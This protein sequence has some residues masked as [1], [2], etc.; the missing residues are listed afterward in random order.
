M[1][2]Y[3]KTPFAPNVPLSVAGFPVYLFGGFNDG[4]SPTLFQVNNVASNG[5]TATLTGFVRAGNIP[6][7][8]SLI[9]TQGLQNLTN[10]SNVAISAVTIN[11]TTGIGTIQ[12][13]D[14]QTV[15]SVAD[16]GAALIP[17]PETSE[18]IANG[19]SIPMTVPYTNAPSNSG[20]RSV[21]AVVSLPTVP[22]T[23][24]V[25]LQS[26]VTNQDSEY[27]DLITVLTVTGSTVSGGQSTFTMEPGRFYRFNVSGL[28]G[29][30]TIIAKL[31][32]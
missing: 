26:A 30:G 8:A 13:L 31:L 16:S 10:V 29:S 28:A 15:S 20:S 24:T 21:K 9:S 27:A 5:T 18:A 1:P 32:A 22:T 25:K 4:I 2:A 11:A 23:L 14:A 12:F 6:A 19:A 3:V 17:Q 7:V